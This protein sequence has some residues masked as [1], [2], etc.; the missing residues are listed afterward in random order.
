MKDTTPAFPHMFEPGRIGR[1][2]LPNRLLMAPMESN[3]AAGNG[4][5]SARQIQYYRDRAAGGVGMVIVEYTCISAPLGIGGVP[6]LWLDD[7]RLITSHA[8]LAAAIRAEGARAC[9]QLFHAGR[10]THPKFTGG[11]QPVAA[12]AIPCPMY[13]KMPRALEPDEIRTLARQYGEAARRAVAAGYDAVEV[14]GAHGYLP[15]N[16]LSG[17]SNI[18]TDEFG[19]SLANRQRFPLLIVE[20]IRALAGDVPLLFR[21]SADEFVEGG[22]T[23]DEATDT[24]R[25]LEHAGVDAIH[26]STGCHERV[27]RNVDPV[28]MPQGWRLPLARAV[29]ETVGIP[30]I[31]VG[32]IR[33]PEVAETALARGDADFIALGRALLADP[34]WPL[35]ARDGRVSDIRPCT[36]CNW[37][38]AQI[39]TGHTPVGC[40]ENPIAGREDLPRPVATG[41]SRQA[42]VVGAGPGGIAAALTLDQCGF[43]VTLFEQAPEIARGLV[44]SAASPGK[45]KFL[46]YRDYLRARLAASSVE[47]RLG[48]KADARA[49]AALSPDLTVLATGG[50]N[51]HLADVSG[52]DQEFVSSA[53]DVLSGAAPLA[54]GRIVIYGAGEIGCE[55]AQYAAGLGRDVILATRSSDDNALSRSNWLRIYREQFVQKLVSNP[56]IRIELGA[57]LTGAEPGRIQFRRDEAT[58]AFDADVLLIAAGRLPDNRLGDSLQALGL[59][60]IT[61]GDAREVRRIGD[62]VHDAY[63]ALSEFTNPQNVKGAELRK[64]AF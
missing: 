60:T 2:E 12:S 4:E 52:L 24:A 38:V 13:R 43:R 16:F 20:E 27:D 15:G 46:W 3:L 34:D 58:L 25:A 6:A 23:I 55:A 35:K 33:E 62:A 29:R 59:R 17:K 5:A 63:W 42:V 61:I 21:L 51:R 64:L 36:S 32:V 7:D 50:T 14:H 18:R 31:G 53:Y 57:R 44:A 41:N 37:C 19:G 22:T 40:A 8:Q 26:V 30:I 54:E 39:G 28:W 47:L 9:V 1:L 56:R 10:Q 49:I 11:E 48:Q 45:D